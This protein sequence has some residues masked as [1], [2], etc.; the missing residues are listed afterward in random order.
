MYD[1]WL[2]IWKTRILMVMVIRTIRR[3]CKKT[4]APYCCPCLHPTF[5]TFT[6]FQRILMMTRMVGLGS[7]PQAREWLCKARR[8][9]ATLRFCCAHSTVNREQSLFNSAKYSELG[10]GHSAQNPF[11]KSKTPLRP[12][13]DGS[14]LSLGGPSPLLLIALFLFLLFDLITL[15]IF[16]FLLLISL[17]LL[18]NIWGSSCHFLLIL[19]LAIIFLIRLLLTILVLI[20]SVILL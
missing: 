2:R 16:I 9:E 11:W 12:L 20:P 19:P 18:L 10:T 5:F 6:F 4:S 17:F 3:L 7:G 15:F 14:P 1:F 8:H 13:D